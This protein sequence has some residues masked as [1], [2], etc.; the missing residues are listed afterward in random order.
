MILLVRANYTVGNQASQEAKDGEGTLLL[1]LGV[2]REI[3]GYGLPEVTKA[4]DIPTIEL[5]L[6]GPCIGSRNA[7]HVLRFKRLGETR[8]GELIEDNRPVRSN[9][10]SRREILDGYCYLHGI[11]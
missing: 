10:K 4:T 11:L 8:L 3:A 5:D 6:H 1:D 9:G 7:Q 2:Y